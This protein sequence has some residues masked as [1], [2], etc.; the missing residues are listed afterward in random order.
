MD[1]LRPAAMAGTFYPADA[2]ALE[3]EL[4][5]LLG[6]VRPYSGHHRPKAII[7]PHAGYVY[8]GA[9]A[10]H[11]Y[12]ALRTAA[13]VVTRVVL[14]GPAHRVPLRGLALPGA[15]AFATPLG[16]AEIDDEAMA[17][18]QHMGI[19]QDPG[20][21]AFEHSLEVQLP[22]LQHVLG[23]FT[24]LPLLVGHA[25]ADA[26]AE[27]LDALWGGPE[28]LIVVSSDLSH[29]LP[30]HEAQ[31]ADRQTAEAILALEGNLTPDQA[32]GAH[33]VNGFLQTA[34]RRALAPNLLDLRN[35][36]DTAGDPGRV[37]GYGSFAFF[38]DAEN[39]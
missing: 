14:L 39:V 22:F 30:Y 35:S 13:P 1:A 9:V 27:T 20:A 38:E 19:P 5:A 15:R 8:S 28:T 6:A 31:E 7:A 24:V 21:H 10:A 2:A 37:V 11:A 4:A 18:A 3:G 32:C 17:R 26:V 29:F 16:L 23:G 36:G 25:R 34:R 12:A 33:A